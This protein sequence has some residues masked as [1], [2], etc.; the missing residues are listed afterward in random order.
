MHYSNDSVAKV[1]R[2][3]PINV[4]SVLCTFLLDGIL[5]TTIKDEAPVI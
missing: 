3:M 4:S 5:N 2:Q 1:R